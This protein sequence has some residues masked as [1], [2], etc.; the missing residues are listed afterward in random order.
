M[1][2]DDFLG[3]YPSG[4]SDRAGHVGQ[5]TDGPTVYDYLV[6]EARMTSLAGDQI[7]L[8]YRADWRPPLDAGFDRPGPARAMYITSIWSHRAGGW[9]NT[10]SQDTPTEPRPEVFEASAEGQL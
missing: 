2:S 6:T 8:S 9:I 1:L 10:F 7:L 3:V 5:L 4:F